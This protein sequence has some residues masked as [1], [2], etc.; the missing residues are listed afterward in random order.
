MRLLVLLMLL[1]LLRALLCSRSRRML[2]LRPETSRG[3]GPTA[4][5]RRSDRP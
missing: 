1:R 3:P 4:Y 2:L 5:K